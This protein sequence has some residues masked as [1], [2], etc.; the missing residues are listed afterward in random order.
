[1]RYIVISMAIAVLCSS[2][3][4]TYYVV[5]HAEKTANDCSAPLATN[6]FTRAGVLR[7]SLHTKGIDSIFVSTC[8]RTQQTGQPLAT[9][10]S[11][12]M[13]QSAT[14]ESATQTL[15]ARLKKIS[16]KQVLVVGHGNTV[17]VIVQALSGEAIDAIPDS[18]YDNLYRIVWRQYKL[19]TAPDDR[20]FRHTGYPPA[21]LRTALAAG[22]FPSL[23]QRL[24]QRYGKTQ[25]IHAGS[26]RYPGQ[27]RKQ[28]GENRTTGLV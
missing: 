8:L 18:D 10:L 24:N 23:C 3:V 14:T 22:F 12:S 15:A 2:C 19:K 16:G 6:G 26:T 11:I 1:M 28:A 25:N 21:V 13:L 9:L 4:T 20:S 7:D 17:P 27:Q 5:R